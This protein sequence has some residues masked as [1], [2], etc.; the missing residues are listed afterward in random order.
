MPVRDPRSLNLVTSS[1]LLCPQESLS[2]SSLMK[3]YLNGPTG[4][5]LTA[6]APD[7]PADRVVRP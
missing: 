3:I 1:G 6:A 7:L 4:A 2:Q 5:L